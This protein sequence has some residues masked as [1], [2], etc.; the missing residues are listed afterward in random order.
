MPRKPKFQ[1]IIPHTL[2]RQE[3]QRHSPPTP[4]Q[5][6][7][8]LTQLQ[9]KQIDI[10]LQ[11]ANLSYW[12]GTLD[13]TLTLADDGLILAASSRDPLPACRL[14]LL[15]CQILLE[16]GRRDA[17][18][19][20][21]TEIAEQ[22]KTAH[23]AVAREVYGGAIKIMGNVYNGRG[24]YN[25]SLR[26]FEEY[27]QIGEELG[28]QDIYANALGN[29]ANVYFTL[30]DYEQFLFCYEEDKRISKATGNLNGYSRA[31]GK[32]G[33]MYAQKGEYEQALQNYEESKNIC[34]ATGNRRGFGAA[35]W[36]IGSVAAAKGDN[37][38]AL[39]CYEEAKHICEASGNRANYA[40]VIVQIG[41][42]SYDKGDFAQ[43]LSYLEEAKEIFK[44]HG[45]RLNYGHTVGAI[46]DFYTKQGQCVQALSY[47]IESFAIQKEIGVH[48]YEFFISVA[49]GLR[50]PEIAD[51]PGMDELTSL[52]GL[53][54]IPDAWFSC[55][56]DGFTRH[57]NLLGLILVLY[58]YGRYLYQS[59]RHKQGLTHLRQAKD[60]AAAVGMKGQLKKIDDICAEL[61][62]T[63]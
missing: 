32:I 43:T 23:S 28:N 41:W 36:G 14:K 60:K 10:I 25:L 58:E 38:Q 1:L 3:R 30:G 57:N 45:Y 16:T 31:L 27:K 35:I 51:H 13:T 63:L 37:E 53:P 15:K 42:L 29:M 6:R 56:I 61:G 49:I 20:L 44:A 22:L 33:S 4:E 54:A 34:E 11:K 19:I 18:L 7:E 52:T 8:R 2:S 48:F 17:A 47:L 9:A 21:A 39:R 55:A 5:A 40:G 12:T 24:D 26:Y 46:G 59:G 62:V 50:R